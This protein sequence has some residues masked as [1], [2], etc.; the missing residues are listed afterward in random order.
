[1][2]SCTEG[3]TYIEDLREQG[4]EREYF[5]PRDKKQQEVITSRI[6]HIK[7]TKYLGCEYKI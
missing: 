1:V 3:R 5:D 7:S 6:G 2:I 4:A